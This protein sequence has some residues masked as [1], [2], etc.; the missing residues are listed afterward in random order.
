MPEAYCPRLSEA[1]E[2]LPLL[3]TH[4]FAAVS[5]NPQAAGHLLDLVPIIDEELFGCELISAG[6]TD[7][8]LTLGGK[9]NRRPVVREVCYR[10]KPSGLC[11]A[12]LDG[13]TLS[14]CDGRVRL[15]ERQCDHEFPD[16]STA[17]SFALTRVGAMFPDETPYPPIIAPGPLHSLEAALNVAHDKLAQWDPFIHFFGLPNE[18][19]LGY[20]LEGAG[21]ERG[22]LVSCNSETWILRWRAGTAAIDE[23]WRV[24]PDAA[25][26]PGRVAPA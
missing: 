6:A 12:T 26:M 10:A 13:R 18:A 14:R 15:R 20:G 16:W 11:L 25:E 24:V 8:Y 19:H 7:T 9:F 4:I 21:D 23:N 5:R 1:G 22:Q 2:L 17:A 3:R